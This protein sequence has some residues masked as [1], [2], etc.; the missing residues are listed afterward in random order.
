MSP[1]LAVQ[2]T[3]TRRREEEPSAN[4]GAIDGPAA[5]HADTRA[6]RHADS[7][8]ANADSRRDT[9]ARRS[10]SDTRCNTDSRRSDIGRSHDASLGHA[11]G[12][13]IDLG[14]R[15][16]R[17]ERHEQRCKSDTVHHLDL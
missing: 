10:G 3:R 16:G 13:A 2:K 17:D 15:R 1:R 14:L 6:G 9:D 8:R 5:I 4:A 7:G 11:D 12:P